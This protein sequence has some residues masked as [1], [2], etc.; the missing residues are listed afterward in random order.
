MGFPS[1]G[2]DV[3][4][5]SGSEQSGPGD[6]AIVPKVNTPRLSSFLRAACQVRSAGGGDPVLH[7]LFGL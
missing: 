6:T 2:V 5:F 3:S 4:C 1:A 7:M